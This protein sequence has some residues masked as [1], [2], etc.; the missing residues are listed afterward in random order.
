MIHFRFVWLIIFTGILF[1]KCQVPKNNETRDSQEVFPAAFRQ[2]LE[3]IG[4][5]NNWRNYGT[6]FFSEVRAQDT[7][8]YTVDLKNRDERIEKP[9]HYTVDF[10]GDSVQIFPNRD[11]FAKNPQFYNNLKFYFFALPYVT[12]DPGTIHED[13]G[14]KM[15]DGKLYDRIKVTF[16]DSVGLA[17]KDQYILWFDHQD[18]LLRLLN[19]S[20][21]YFDENNDQMAA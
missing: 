20:V 5:L 1:S 17:P 9:G 12:A 4:G 13:L 19:Y 7:I 21:T 14:S 8:K 18:H 11:S 16:E 15:F 6:L 3:N 2:S 10:I